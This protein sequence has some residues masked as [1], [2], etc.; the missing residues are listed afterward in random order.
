[1][2]AFETRFLFGKFLK[3][4]AGGVTEKFSMIFFAGLQS[5]PS[6]KIKSITT[7][8]AIK[9]PFNEFNTTEKGKTRLK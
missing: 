2:R 1:M 3:F 4:F 9:Q 6:E 7:S 8:R 5:F